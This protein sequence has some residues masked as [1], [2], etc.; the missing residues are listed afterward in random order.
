M[1]GK[2]WRVSTTSYFWGSEPQR[3]RGLL[4]TVDSSFYRFLHLSKKNIDHHY[5][6]LKQIERSFAN[7]VPV[8]ASAVCSAWTVLLHTREKKSDT[9]CVYKQKKKGRQ[10]V[11]QSKA[12]SRK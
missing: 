6:Y 5:L 4:L 9:R 12:K 2:F 1:R 7:E 8:I 3:A 11:K 10:A